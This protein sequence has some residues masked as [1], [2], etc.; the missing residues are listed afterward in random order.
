MLDVVEERAAR[1]R[2]R[3]GDVTTWVRIGQRHRDDAV[4]VERAAARAR[5]VRRKTRDRVVGPGATRGRDAGRRATDDNSEQQ[6]AHDR[7]RAA[8]R[9]ARAL[10]TPA[11]QATCYV[12]T[13]S[14]ASDSPAGPSNAGPRLLRLAAAVVAVIASAI[15]AGDA[16]QH[17][18]VRATL[19]PVWT[20]AATACVASAAWPG[21]QSRRRL[22]AVHGAAL[23]CLAG[24]C[25]SW[26]LRSVA[27]P[28]EPLGDQVACLESR[29]SQPRSSQLPRSPWSLSH[30]DWLTAN[31]VRAA[32]RGGSVSRDGA[33]ASA[34]GPCAETHLPCTPRF[35]YTRPSCSLTVLSGRR[36]DRSGL[37]AVPS[38]DAI[39]NLGDR[40]V[41]A[42][43]RSSSHEGYRLIT[44][45]DI[46]RQELTR[47]C[48]RRRTDP[49][50][51]RAHRVSASSASATHDR[52]EQRGSAFSS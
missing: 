52:A 7:S 43:A 47:R 34:R 35:R 49:L 33:A 41:P 45:L 30:E 20:L 14:P 27:E 6:V 51:A 50:G 9:S 5:G 22:A 12:A 28:S 48:R 39:T 17:T 44:H 38:C 36:S 37:D 29:C 46:D 8:S 21:V 2:P 15:D 16:I 40:A 10:S 24:A 19:A 23:V 4:G 32:W 3:H 25:W 1:R 42:R 18:G 26:A 11:S 13:M 31:S